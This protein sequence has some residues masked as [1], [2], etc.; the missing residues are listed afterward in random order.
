M[1]YY[2]AVASSDEKNIDVSFGAA[3]EFLIYKVDDVSYTLF[4]KREFL[5]Q[6]NSVD[7]AQT[8]CEKGHG[9]GGGSG[10][11]KSK[12]GCGGDTGIQKKIEIIKDCRCIVCLKIGFHVQKQL[13]KLAISSFDVACEI[14]EALT[15]ITSYYS[16]TDKHL[17][18]RKE[19]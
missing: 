16:K 2:I 3:K 9:C 11:G 14:E 15:K 18:L 19:V 12:A 6:D 8:V 5:E 1:A 10:C 17:S 4:E 7:S 13:E